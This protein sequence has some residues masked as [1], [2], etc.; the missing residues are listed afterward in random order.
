MSPLIITAALALVA[1]DAA[2][3]TSPTSAPAPAAAQAKGPSKA[4]IEYW[5]QMTCED[6][7]YVGSRFIRHICVTRMQRWYQSQRT[8]EL[9]RR[10]GEEVGLPLSPDGNSVPYN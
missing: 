2:P 5:N 4:E 8:G 3:A 10:M 9:K 6:R 7:P 1:F